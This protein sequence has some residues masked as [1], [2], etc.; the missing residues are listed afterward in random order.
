M[1]LVEKHGVENNEEL[2]HAGDARGLGVLAI[3]TQSQ[4]VSSDGG[5]AANSGHCSHIQDAPNLGA[6]TPD[7]TAAAHASAV[8]VKWC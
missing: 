2:A 6:S 7:T 3:G 4:I 8:A 5:I 1:S